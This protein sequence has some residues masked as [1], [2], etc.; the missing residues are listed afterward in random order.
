MHLHQNRHRITGSSNSY[1]VCLW[2]FFSSFVCN[3]FFSSF[4]DVHGTYCT[5]YII[6]IWDTK[7]HLVSW[8]SNALCISDDPELSKDPIGS[9]ATKVSH[10]KHTTTNQS[11]WGKTSSTLIQNSTK[12]IQFKDIRYETLASLF[13]LFFFVSKTIKNG[14]FSFKRRNYLPQIH[15]FVCL[16]VFLRCCAAVLYMKEKHWSG[17]DL[18][19][20]REP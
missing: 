18:E 11:T 7:N 10:P 15:I 9:R 19:T 6:D 4:A 8:S 17:R 2:L 5:Q 1:F 12:T 3:I 20:G 13:S 14:R 16:F